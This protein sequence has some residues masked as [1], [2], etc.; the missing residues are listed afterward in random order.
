MFISLDGINVNDLLIEKNHNQH[1]NLYITFINI[2]HKKLLIELSCTN[3]RINADEDL[4]F[5]NF[6]IVGKK[7]FFSKSY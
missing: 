5:E 3:I 6:T 7:Q 1:M 4:V 2:Q